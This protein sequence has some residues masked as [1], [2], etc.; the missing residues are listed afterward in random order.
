M[1]S[2]IIRGGGTYREFQA[3][4][5]ATWPNLRGFLFVDDHIYWKQGEGELAP[6][7]LVGGDGTEVTLRGDQR[8][9]DAHAEVLRTFKVNLEL[10]RFDG[11]RLDLLENAHRLDDVGA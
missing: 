8:E 5:V 3:A 7:D 6:D 10:R 2:L 4:L 11:G 1:K 9:A